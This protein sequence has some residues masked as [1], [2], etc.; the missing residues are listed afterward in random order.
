MKYRKT[1]TQS[2]YNDIQKPRTYLKPSIKGSIILTLVVYRSSTGQP[3]SCLMLNYANSWYM[4][5]TSN[6]NLSFVNANLDPRSNILTITPNLRPVFQTLQPLPVPCDLRV[7]NIPIRPIRRHYTHYLTPSNQ[8]HK[9]SQCRFN[10]CVHILRHPR[11]LIT[12]IIKM[13]RHLL[14][15]DP[16]VPL[17]HLLHFFG[18]GAKALGLVVQYA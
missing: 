9:L 15:D 3:R 14:R 13:L 12:K 5:V 6:L 16:S 1:H 4:V 17:L 11:P 7:H 2:C 8:L 18:C 10:R